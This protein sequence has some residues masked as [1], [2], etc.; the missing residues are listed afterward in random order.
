[1]K[2]INLKLAA[3]AMLLAIFMIPA[4][5]QARQGQ[6]QRQGQDQRQGQRQGQGQGQGQRQRQQ[7]T[8]AD[9]VD[10]VD[11]LAESLK[12]NDEQKTKVLTFEKQELK[13]TQAMREQMA[14]TRES[15]GQFDREAMRVKMQEARDLREKEY[16]VIF[17]KEQ[18]T[19][20]IKL[21][22]ERNQNR[23]RPGD[24]QQQQGDRPSR[25]RGR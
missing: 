10:R 19:K 22:D 25:G 6:G 18:Y 8:E 11:R 5:G 2:T 7:M 3:L 23:Q 16:K 13:K 9:V 15:G 24:S 17:T 1:M 20:Y 14:A 21:R 12:L 4:S